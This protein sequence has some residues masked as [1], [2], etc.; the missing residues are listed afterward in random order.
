MIDEWDGE[1]CLAC[2]DAWEPQGG[3]EYDSITGEELSELSLMDWRD[4]EEFECPHCGAVHAIVPDGYKLTG[5]TIPTATAYGKIQKAL[6][7]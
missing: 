4:G 6:D 1:I 3:I 5:E 7:E 2:G